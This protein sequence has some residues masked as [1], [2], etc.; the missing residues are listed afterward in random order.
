MG[1]ASRD[2]G[3]RRELQVIHWHRERGYR[4]ERVPDSGAS[5][6]NGRKAD[7]DAYLFGSENAPMIF[8]SKGRA[9]FKTLW[10]W[11]GTADGLVLI[12]DRQPPLFVLSESA[13]ERLL[14]AA[15]RAP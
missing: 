2:K 7:I 10:G 13:Y 14:Q 15:K 9:S 4:C 12:G 6:Y 8:E 5:G 11:L 3:R 1:K